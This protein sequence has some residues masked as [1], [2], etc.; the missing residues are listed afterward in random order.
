[1]MRKYIFTLCILFLTSSV[2]GALKSQEIEVVRTAYKIDQYKYYIVSA[3]KK[4]NIYNVSL[5]RESSS[6]IMFF[7]IQVQCSPRA[8]KELGSSK[9]SASDIKANYAGQWY[10]PVIGSI[11]VDVITTVCR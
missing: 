6:A 11:E 4:S 2:C 1:M 8:F 5:K 7:K 9:K 10:T 3:E